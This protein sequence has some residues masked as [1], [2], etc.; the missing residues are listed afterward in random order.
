VRRRKHDTGVKME[1]FVIDR[2]R[3]SLQDR[4]TTGA[5]AHY[6]TER[7][8]RLARIKGRYDPGNRFRF[9]LNI[10]PG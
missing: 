6:D 9:N 2:L 1:R 3:E 5:D 7:F 8:A 4:A 10:A